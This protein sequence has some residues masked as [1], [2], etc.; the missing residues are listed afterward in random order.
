MHVFGLFVRHLVKV[1]AFP[2][3]KELMLQLVRLRGDL[4]PQVSTGPY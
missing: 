4:D 3:N 2:K 1:G